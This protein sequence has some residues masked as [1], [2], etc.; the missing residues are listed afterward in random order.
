MTGA[1]HEAGG[2]IFVQLWHVGRVSHTP[3]AER[4][5]AGRPGGGRGQDEDLPRHGFTEVSAPRAWKH[6]IAGIV[7]DYANAAAQGRRAGFDG[8]EIHGANGYLLDQF[9]RDPQPAHRRLRRLDRNRLR[10]T[11]KATDAMLKAWPAARVGYRIS[12]VSPANDLADSDPQALFGALTAELSKRKPRLSP[13]RRGRD[14][15]PARRRAVRLRRDAQDFCG[16][17]I[18]NNG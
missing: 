17:Y 16:A 8:V 14:R 15:R 11:L 9:L 12:P 1:V 4:R 10:S 3:A 5:R 13:C 6:E 2:H 7:A 18:A